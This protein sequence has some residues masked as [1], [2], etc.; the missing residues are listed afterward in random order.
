LMRKTDEENDYLHKEIKKLKQ[1]AMKV[2]NFAFCT[3]YND[4]DI[5]SSFDLD[6]ILEEMKKDEDKLN[7][8]ITSLK[9][10]FNIIID[11]IKGCDTDEKLQKLKELNT[12]DKSLP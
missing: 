11:L 3:K 6:A 5:V 4:E 9:K 8:G 10:H 1:F 7:E 2:H 12:L